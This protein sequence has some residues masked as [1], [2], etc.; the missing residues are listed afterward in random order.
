MSMQ[1]NKFKARYVLLVLIGISVLFSIIKSLVDVSIS[2]ID[3]SLAENILYI[4]VFG[5]VCLSIA[6]RSRHCD[7]KIN[8]IIGNLD[9]KNIPWFVLIIIFYGQQNLSNGIN[10]LESFALLC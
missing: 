5:S 2:N 4:V 6:W 3:N 8:Q 10:Y 9:I 7:I 1:F